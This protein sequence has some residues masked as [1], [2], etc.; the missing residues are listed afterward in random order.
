MKVDSMKKTVGLLFLL[1]I[2]TAC[3]PV[4]KV[5]KEYQRSPDD[6][7]S[8]SVKTDSSVE[9]PQETISVLEDRLTAELTKRNMFASSDS[10][11]NR[12][13]E[14][15]INKYNMRSDGARFWGGIFAGTDIIDTLVLVKSHDGGETLAEF[16]LVSKNESA[17]GSSKGMIEEHADLIVKYLTGGLKQ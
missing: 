16:T 15:T 3:A 14:I 4:L 13:I 5:A 8:Y 1:I 2:V 9:V 7:F 17:W 12:R 10:D 11:K 6:L